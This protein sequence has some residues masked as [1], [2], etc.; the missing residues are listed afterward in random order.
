MHLSFEICMQSRWI[1]FDPGKSILQLLAYTAV[2][3]DVSSNTFYDTEGF[4]TFTYPLWTSVVTKQLSKTWLKSW[5]LTHL[6]I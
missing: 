3:K 5:V 6:A 4:V 1:E 2:N